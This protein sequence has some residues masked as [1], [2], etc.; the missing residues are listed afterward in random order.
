MMSISNDT[1]TGLV[2]LSFYCRRCDVSYTDRKSVEAVL[3][4][5]SI[6]SKPWL[7]SQ[8][9]MKGCAA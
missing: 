7:I 9:R 6:T 3:E 4:R 5:L 2:I 1:G 8:L